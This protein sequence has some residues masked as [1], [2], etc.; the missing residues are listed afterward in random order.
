LFSKECN[1]AQKYKSIDINA[2]NVLSGFTIKENV[3]Q[4]KDAIDKIIALDKIS[5]LKIY[6]KI[7]YIMRK[8]IISV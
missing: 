5:I 1:G 4:S 8:C 2:L 7:I 6:E 3:S